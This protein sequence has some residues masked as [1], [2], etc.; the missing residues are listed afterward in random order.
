MSQTIH[1]K[2]G[3]ITIKCSV[4][5]EMKFKKKKYQLVGTWLQ[6][7]DIEAFGRDALMLICENCGHVMHFA[8]PDSIEDVPV[9]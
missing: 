5:N 4:C 3:N 2:V 7:L 6:S 1:A 9:Q 8:H